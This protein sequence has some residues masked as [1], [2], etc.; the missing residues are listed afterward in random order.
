MTSHLLKMRKKPAY[1]FSVVIVLCFVFQAHSQPGK[2][3]V[4]KANEIKGT[5]QPTM[6]GIFFEDINMGADGGV[7]AELVK[8]RSF[9]F[10]S[11]LMGWKEVKKDGGEG[12]VLVI[13]RGQQNES[14]PRYIKVKVDSQKGYGL[15]NEGFRGIGVKQNNQY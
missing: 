8:N 14:N 3:Y 2:T 11:P 13:N 7:Y 1:L 5:V 6:W 15:S 9:E 4:V 12:S 10:D